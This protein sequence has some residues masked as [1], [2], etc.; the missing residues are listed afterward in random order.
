MNK[1]FTVDTF[2]EGVR[3]DVY[4]TRQLGGSRTHV[5]KMIKN[6]EI[7]VN[8][9]D[10]CVPHRALKAN[11]LVEVASVASLPRNDNQNSAHQSSHSF[12]K[13][14][15]RVFKPRQ[16]RIV[17][18]TLFENKDV[19]VINKHAGDLVH[20]T[21]QSNEDTVMHAAI[22]HDRHIANV[23]DEP[24]T[25]AGIVHRLDRMA[26][27]VLM[28][29]KTQEAFEHLKS[30]FQNRLAVKQYRTLVEGSLDNDVGTITRKIARSQKQRRMVARP[31]SQEGKEAVTH[32]TVRQRSANAT[33]L[34]IEIETGRTHQIRVHLHSTGHPVVG[35]SL[36]AIKNQKRIAFDRLWLHAESLAI[37]L[38]SESEPRT[39]TAPLPTELT[40]LTDMLH[41]V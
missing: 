4:L 7:R 34:D 12:W 8:G 23:G 31:V 28:I 21:E 15:S 24:A 26:S 33:E 2:D 17:L 39:F 5:Q 29:A 37:L 38:P 25:R 19:L 30:Q 40:Q 14:L 10:E 16:Y 11:D 35:D 22:R 32:Y 13:R 3:L 1:S 18:D 6:G 20:P 41:K 27:G 36:Y 9:A